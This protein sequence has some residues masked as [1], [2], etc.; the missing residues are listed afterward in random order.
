MLAHRTRH[1]VERLTADAIRPK[2]EPFAGIGTDMPLRVILLVDLDHLGDGVHLRADGPAH[3]VLQR[4]PLPIG[5]DLVSELRHI[6]LMDL[7][8]ILRAR[9]ERLK[10]PVYPR[11]AGLREYHAAPD[12][13]R[14]VAHDPLA[15]F[16]ADAHFLQRRLQRLM[17]DAVVFHLCDD[18]GLLNG[19]IA[20]LV[21]HL[22]LEHRD[23]LG[24]WQRADDFECIH[25]RSLLNLT[26]AWSA[27]VAHSRFGTKGAQK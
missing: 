13:G 8:P 6:L 16:D 22:L 10:L 9:G 7:E 23:P 14:S 27:P 21:E 2:R 4:A 18:P 26:I 17:G 3:P 19:G 5:Q 15:R 24:H 11:R 25:S 12:A 1:V 20:G